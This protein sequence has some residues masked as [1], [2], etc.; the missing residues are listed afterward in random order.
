MQQVV[1]PRPE[2]ILVE[3]K[4]PRCVQT[5]SAI[6]RHMKSSERLAVQIQNN[7]TARIRSTYLEGLLDIHGYHLTVMK[8]ALSL[9]NHAITNDASCT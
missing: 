9:K 2:N 7:T 6:Q 8:R 4:T 3:R 1:Q 5:R